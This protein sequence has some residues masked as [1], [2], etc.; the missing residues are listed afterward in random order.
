MRS[1]VVLSASLLLLVSVAALASTGDS[2]PWDN[3]EITIGPIVLVW[4]VVV[5]GLIQ[6]LKGV[7]VGNPPRPLLATPQSIWLAN[8]ALGGVGVLV[9]ELVNGAQLLQ[10][11]LNAITAIVA[12]VGVFEGAKTAAGKEN[13]TG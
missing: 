10:A 6:V 8:V 2:M 13:G 5:S 9:Y 1:L 3:L 7:R 4:G 12:A 11:I